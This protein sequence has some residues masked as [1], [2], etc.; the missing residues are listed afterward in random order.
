LTDE[1]KDSEWLTTYLRDAAQAPR[2]SEADESHL[3]R[4]ME[5]GRLASRLA[6]LG[7]P[8]A[9]EELELAWSVSERARQRLL[10]ANRRYVV[11]I[12]QCS[13]SDEVSFEQLVLRGELGLSR[14]AQR[15]RPRHHKRFAFY[16]TWWARQ[17]MRAN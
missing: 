6:A 4:L 10:E 5:G 11:A 9:R 15:W 3:G 7:L 13:V 14:A 17:A 8:V 12:A 1:A 16:A 2:L